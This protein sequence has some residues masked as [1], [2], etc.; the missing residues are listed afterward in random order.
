MRYFTEI[1]APLYDL[2]CKEVSWHWIETEKS[3]MCSLCT[4]LYCHPVLALPD[5]TRPFCIESDASETAVGGVL[6][7]EHA[8]VQ[9]PIA[10]LI[11]TLTS[12]K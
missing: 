8:S 12:S 2:L 9:K 7:Q 3:D 5:S 4:S 1:A 11:N 6:T 10:F